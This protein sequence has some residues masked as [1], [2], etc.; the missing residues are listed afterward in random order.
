LVKLAL[1]TKSK[2]KELNITNIEK[3]QRDSS[4]EKVVKDLLQYV[5]NLAY[6]LTLKAI[7]KHKSNVSFVNLIYILVFAVIISALVYYINKERI[8]KILKK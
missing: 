1:F 4:Y 6:S 5:I 2:I 7:E 8:G 3:S